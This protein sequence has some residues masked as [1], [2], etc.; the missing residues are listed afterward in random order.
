[1]RRCVECSRVLKK[2]EAQLCA[3]CR[4]AVLPRLVPEGEQEQR[5]SLPTDE[6]DS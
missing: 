2:G 5:D 6:E 3:R 4:D 1:M